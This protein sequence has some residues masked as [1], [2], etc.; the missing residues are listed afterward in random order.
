MVAVL[1]H[2]CVVWLVM[3]LEIQNKLKMASVTHNRTSFNYDLM[4][5]ELNVL[6]HRLLAWHE[7]PAKEAEVKL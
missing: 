7:L 5:V 1:R 2:I 6:V 4:E 3:L